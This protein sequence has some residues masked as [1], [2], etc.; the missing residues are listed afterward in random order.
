MSG[1]LDK[2]AHGHQKC[3]FIVMVKL[4]CFGIEPL[5]GSQKLNWA[6]SDSTFWDVSHNLYKCVC[7][8]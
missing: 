2:D 5:P 1:L 6:Q 7:N 4:E 3:L 8:I